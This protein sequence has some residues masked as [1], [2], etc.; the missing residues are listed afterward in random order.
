[1]K[2]I[3]GILC[4]ITLSLAGVSCHGDLDIAQKGQ[5]TGGDAWGSQ[6]NALANMYGMMSTFR[7]AFATDYMYW[8]EYRTQ[9]WGKGNETQPSR[10]F[11][12]TN[13]IASTHAQADWT[14]LYTTINHANLIL[15]Y[16]PGIGF[17]DEGQKNQILGAAH[18]VRVL[19]LL[20]RPYLG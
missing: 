11:V 8:G 17:T 1:M 2:K 5:V 18:F 20:D 4:L 14:S 7:A 6:S 12:Y 16:V 10:D 15:K 13:N 19:L 9:I 3:F